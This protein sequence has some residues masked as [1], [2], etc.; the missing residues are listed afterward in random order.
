MHALASYRY[1]YAFG[2]AD[3]QYNEHRL[4]L[5]TLFSPCRMRDAAL[6]FTAL[7]IGSAR[8]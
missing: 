7:I 2:K 5:A 6:P 1:L 8:H 4:P 3:V